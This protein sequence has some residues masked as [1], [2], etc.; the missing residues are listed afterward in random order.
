MYRT[1]PR[2]DGAAKSRSA[3]G[4]GFQ[5]DPSR[6]ATWEGRAGNVSPVIKFAGAG[7][8]RADGNDESVYDATSGWLRSELQ[9]NAICRTRLAGGFAE[10]SRC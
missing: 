2:K 7:L 10:P 6:R 4:H 9:D 1:S 8:E 5:D 3:L